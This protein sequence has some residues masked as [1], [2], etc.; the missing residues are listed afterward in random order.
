MAGSFAAGVISYTP[1]DADVKFTT[2]SAALGAPGGISGENS[3]A[4]NYF[5]FPNVVSPFSPPYQGDEV[6][7]IGEGGQITLRLANFVTVGAG[8]RLGVIN[9]V[10]LQDADNVNF[11]GQNGA[12][13]STFGGGTAHVKVSADNQSWVDLGVVTF[14]VP[15]LYYVNAG[16]YDGAAP[17][18]PQLTD[19]G[20]PFEGTLASFNGKNYAGTVA[21]FAAAGGGYS[22]GGT[23]LDLSGTGLASVGYVQFLEPDDGNPLTKA[24]FAFDAV[25]IANGAV[26]APT[27]E[28]SAALGALVVGVGAL[29]GSRRRRRH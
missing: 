10:G 27:P 25:S 29:L 3:A 20:K 9:N 17:A 28:P 15:T 5:G 7:Q 2:P 11:S 21:A 12:T 24:R 13:A 18:S 6:V 8:K 22:G 16:P 1:G 14:D 19:F 4:S 23:W 26:G